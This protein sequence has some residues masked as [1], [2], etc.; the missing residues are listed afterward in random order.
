MHLFYGFIAMNKVEYSLM[1]SPWSTCEWIMKGT[2]NS[3]GQPNKETRDEF[4]IS[5]PEQRL[6]INFKRWVR[7]GYTYLLIP[8]QWVWLSS[9]WTKPSKAGDVEGMRERTKKFQSGR[10]WLVLCMSRFGPCVESSLGP[11]TS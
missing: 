10:V 1:N 6:G 7:R 11:L 3:S 4:Q 9:L 5:L 8:I 2:I